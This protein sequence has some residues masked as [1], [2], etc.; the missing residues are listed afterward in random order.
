MSLAVPENPFRIT[1]SARF[2]Y[3]GQ[4]DAAL[5]GLRVAVAEGRDAAVLAEPGMGKTLL[6]RLL[7]LAQQGAWDVRHAAAG[8]GFDPVPLLAPAEKPLIVMV[9]EAHALSALQLRRIWETA[10]AR[11]EAGAT[12][13]LILAGRPK[14]EPVAAEA[15]LTL[16]WFVLAGLAAEAIPNLVRGRLAVAGCAEDA[17]SEEALQE[18]AERSRGVPRLLNLACSHALFRAHA[19]RAER[20]TLAH[21]QA[22]AEALELPAR[23]PA[24]E[25]PSEAE[26][27]PPPS[28]VVGQAGAAMSEPR[29]RNGSMGWRALASGLGLF[30]GGLLGL[31]LLLALAEAE[32]PAMQ[33]AT[34][35][36][37]IVATP[38]S[39]AAAESVAPTTAAAA[40]EPE[41]AAPRVMLH[42]SAFD[43]SGER[44]ARRLAASLVE[45]GYEAPSVGAVRARI[46]STTIRYF[47][48]EDLDEAARLRQLVAHTLGQRGGERASVQDLT[49]YEPK[50]SESAIEIW[51]GR[52]G[53]SQSDDNDL[54]RV[55]ATIAPPQLKSAG[56]RDWP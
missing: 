48:P 26:P 16:E 5:A 49:H 31:V 25:A 4:L 41:R 33:V 11:R 19:E 23:R 3:P 21:A 9:D 7:E 27:P 51:L 10:Q 20:V 56:V 55:R 17:F 18:L 32:P 36:P 52:G 46:D 39:A 53:A 28:T 43:H 45:N 2:V 22:A 37:V 24:P 12:I 50:P 47:F 44:A 35:A 14:F 15:E 1:P 40:A 29:R 13:S 42:Y 34:M 38:A 54:R 8:L 30:I 6:L